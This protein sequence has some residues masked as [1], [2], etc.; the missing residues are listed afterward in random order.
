MSLKSYNRPQLSAAA[1]ARRE[2]LM[3]FQNRV[4]ESVKNDVLKKRQG[5]GNVTEQVPAKKEHPLP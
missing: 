2:T 1:L 3:A 5:S 4:A